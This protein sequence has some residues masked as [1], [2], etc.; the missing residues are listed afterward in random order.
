MWKEKL[1]KKAGFTLIELLIALL[2]TAMVS[3]LLLISYKQYVKSKEKE[4][5]MLV[6]FI[7][8]NDLMQ[9][10]EQ[11]VGKG[12]LSESGEYGGIKYT[13]TSR[14]VSRKYILDPTENRK[15]KLIL[16]RIDLK[17]GA[18]SYSWKVIKDEE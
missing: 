11:K 6:Y 12:L 2:I 13:Y 8:L 5:S 15:I 14:I 9:T 7:L 4:N 16:F 3:S 17:F 10:V 18:D 1:R